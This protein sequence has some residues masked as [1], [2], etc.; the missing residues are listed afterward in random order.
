M[1]CAIKHLAVQS[2]CEEVK[3]IRI[4]DQCSFYNF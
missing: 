1:S 2:V 3:K 4:D